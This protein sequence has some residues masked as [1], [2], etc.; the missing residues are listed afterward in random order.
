[1]APSKKRGCLNVTFHIILHVRQAEAWTEEGGDGQLR[2][3]QNFMHAK[4][5]YF[6]YASVLC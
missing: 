5:I 2:H 3:N 1:M 4:F 6:F